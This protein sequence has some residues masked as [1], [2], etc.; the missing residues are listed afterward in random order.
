[1]TVAD[2]LRR[3]APVIR[4]A[5]AKLN[6]TL[7]VTGRRDDGYHS[8]HSV[9]V[10]LTLSDRLSLAPV[11][12]HADT[13]HVSGLDAG[14]PADNLVFRAIAAARTAVGGGH[15]GGPAPAPALAAR[16]EKRIPVAAGL[17]GGSSDAAAALDGALE[18]WGAELD[19]AT[20][21]AVAARLGSDVPFFLAGGPALV[22]GRGETVAA[23]HGLHGTPG[24]LLVTPVIAV[25]TP[26]VFAAFDAIRNQGDGAVRMSSAHLA[27]E[28]RAGLSAADL[29][30]RAGVLA[31]ANDLL[32][33]TAL[34]VPALVPFKRSLSRL[35]GRPI[36]LSGSGPTLWALYPSEADAIAAAETVRTALR[37]GTVDAPGATDPFITATAIIGHT[38]KG[39]G[40]P[41]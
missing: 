39:E 5:P 9:F 22:E 33:A 1:M 40:E 29:V 36:G 32:P 18:A 11:A 35:L 28:L 17:A 21:H 16:L 12:G 37:E 30:A 20:H 10:P 19:E 26:D 38:R 25:S 6:L 2:P 31:A 34:V 41:S 8:L 15:P 4:L 3:L 14:P 13:L 24:V 27:E 23:L 7:A